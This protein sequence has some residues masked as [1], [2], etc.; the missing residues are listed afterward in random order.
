M[1]ANLSE[2]ATGSYASEAP[3]RAT[4]SH[5][6]VFRWPVHTLSIY[7]LAEGVEW[8]IHEGPVSAF[9][10]SADSSK[11]AIVEETTEI[12]FAHSWSVLDVDSGDVSLITT[13]VASDQFLFV[14]DFFDQYVESHNIWS[15]DSSKIVIS[16]L[17]LDLEEV[18]RPN[19]DLELPPEFGSQIW[20]LDVSGNTD[21][22][23]LGRG[24]LAIWPD[25]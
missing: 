3:L 17:L 1:L 10:W 15:L 9:W 25:Q 5:R 23:S 14:Q 13:Y 8:T 18:I 22:V 19:G 6:K 24:T 20:V 11:L 16:G 12:E 21:P 7:D 2:K 4:D